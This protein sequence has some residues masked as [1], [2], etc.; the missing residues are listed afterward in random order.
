LLPL[1][2]LLRAHQLGPPQLKSL[3]D[4]IGERLIGPDGELLVYAFALEP[5]MDSAVAARERRVA[6]AIDPEATSMSALFEALI[7]T[8]RPW[9]TPLVISV[10]VFIVT[11]LYLDLRS[12]RLTSLAVLPVLVGGFVTLG[13]LDWFGM[14]FNTVT[15]VGIPLL[16]GLGVDD[17]VH[18]VHR[19]IEEPERRIDEVVTSVGRG[20]AMTTATTCAS[21]AALLFSE[22]PGIESIALLLLI[23]LPLC[24]L[25]SALVLPAGAVLLG[26][27]GSDEK[28]LAS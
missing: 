6:Q 12:L 3:P 1:R 25:A 10:L 14:A 5:A 24:L 22:H 26:F 27:G 15:L 9:M 19:M 7:G 17:G 4:S 21:V 20:I 23:G 18:I 2:V 16:L 8:E 11:I 13:V 28:E